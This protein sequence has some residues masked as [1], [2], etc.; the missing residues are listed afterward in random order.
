MIK[1]YLLQIVLPLV[2]PTAVYL[3]W[4]WL[5]RNR[6]GGKQAP[7]PWT[8]LVLGGLGLMVLGFVVLG[9]M[10]GSQPGA[11][12]TPPTLVDGEIVPGHTN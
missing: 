9:L 1:N 12:Y 7:A 4:R 10:G 3:V 2:L 6:T 8:W 11:T 5:T